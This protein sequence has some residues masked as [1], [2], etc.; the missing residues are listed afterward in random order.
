[1]QRTTSAALVPHPFSPPTLPGWRLHGRTVLPTA[2]SRRNCSTSTCSCSKFADYWRWG[3]QAQCDFTCELVASLTSAM[4]F[5]AVRQCL[6]W[7]HLTR[8]RQK[9]C[10]R[11]AQAATDCLFLAC[12]FLA[13]T[14]ILL[15]LQ[16]CVTSRARLRLLLHALDIK[17][18]PPVHPLLS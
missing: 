1:M 8:K 16:V 7:F 14:L 18:H 3:G 4:L 11:K 17:F 9:E 12:R 10:T 13:T 6:L 5:G 15:L 2:A